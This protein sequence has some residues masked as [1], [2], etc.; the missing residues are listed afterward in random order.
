MRRVAVIGVGWYQLAEK[1]FSFRREPDD[2][3]PIVRVEVFHTEPQCFLRLLK[4][5]TSH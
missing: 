2:L 4:F 3:E 1:R 5:G